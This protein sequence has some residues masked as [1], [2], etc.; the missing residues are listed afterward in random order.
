MK[1]E[2]SE[3]P[4]F[5][6]DAART[7][8]PSFIQKSA[9]NLDAGTVI[10]FGDEWEK[11]DSFD[12]EDLQNAGNEYFDIVNESMLNASSFVLDA[13]CGS[14]RW[15]GF[16]ADRVQ[17]VDA[18]DPSHAVFAASRLLA[19]KKNVRISQASIDHLPFHDNTFD[20]ILCLGVLHH[21]PDTEK[22]LRDLVKKLKPGGH[23]LLY[24]YYNLENRGAFYKFLFSIVNLKRRVISSLPKSLKHFCCDVIALMIYL[25]LVSVARFFKFIFPK[26]SFYQRIPLSYYTNKS[27]RIMRN[28]ALD[29]FGTPLEKR[30]SREEIRKMMEASELDD[31]RFSDNQPYWHVVGR[32]T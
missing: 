2:Y 8:I 6:L 23:V 1:P 20:F 29:R 7:N 22:A 30:Y 3:E 4:T 19:D 31:I 15:T 17:H 9:L 10:S 21:I 13:G 11:F 25:P 28:D 24:F 16:I 32:R 18:I 27:F 5:Y 12:P 26:S 14:G